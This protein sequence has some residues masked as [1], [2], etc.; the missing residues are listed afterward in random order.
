[1][2]GGKG[3]LFTLDLMLA[4]VPVA[5]VLG[6]SASAMSGVS[7]QIMDYT[8]WFTS[9]RDVYDSLDALVKTPG[10]PVDWHTNGPSVTPGLAY[11]TNTSGYEG[12]LLDIEKINKLSSDPGILANIVGNRYS[13]YNLSFRN[14]TGNLTNYTGAVVNGSRD[15][16]KYIYASKRLGLLQYERS[17][18][19][20]TLMNASYDNST[21]NFWNGGK[22][23]FRFSFYVEVGETSDHDFWLV[24]IANDTDRNNG[25]IGP[26]QVDI[27]VNPDC[28]GGTGD[29]VF[30]CKPDKNYAECGVCEFSSD[31]CCNPTAFEGYPEGVT[32]FSN[33]TDY[34]T[35]GVINYV[36]LTIPSGARYEYYEMFLIKEDQGTCNI[37]IELSYT[38]DVILETFLEVGR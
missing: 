36:C 15:S 27:S 25:N 28:S 4:L 12:L 37:D 10:D 19:R 26:A 29:N 9:E 2:Q 23:V 33:I 17:F 7:T 18:A 20:S 35:E 1:M 30:P 31:K 5:I 34:V 13:Y 8:S 11:Y 22:P 32:A 24:T 3:Q 14:I 16:C 38:E 6:L 21:P